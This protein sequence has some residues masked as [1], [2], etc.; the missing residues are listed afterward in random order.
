MALAG[1]DKKLSSRNFRIVVDRETIG[2]SYELS[3]PMTLGSQLRERDL[4]RKVKARLQR[5]SPQKMA[6]AGQTIMAYWA[7][8]DFERAI[9]AIS[10]ADRMIDAFRKERLTPKIV[11]EVLGISAH[12]RRRW[13]KD[14]RLPKSGTGQFKKGRQVFQFYLHPVEKIAKLAA[15]P[16]I[17]AEWREADSQTVD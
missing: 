7:R 4:R 6:D 10:D 13:T 5:W 15:S 9:L 1:D 8:R 11:E 14:G 3:R 16:K 17:I 12:E 2:I